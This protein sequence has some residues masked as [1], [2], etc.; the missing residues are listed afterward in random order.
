MPTIIGCSPEMSAPFRTSND[1]IF[2]YHQRLSPY[3]WLRHGFSL[4]KDRNGVEMSYA[5]NEYQATETVLKNRQRLVRSVSGTELRLAT[6]RQM[7]SDR[8]FRASQALLDDPPQGDGWVSAEPQLL[9]AVQTAD[10]LPL[11]LVD[12]QQRVVAAVH[13]GWRGAL[14]RIAQKAVCRMQTD[15]RS[16]PADCLAISGPAIRRCCYEVGDELVDAF[17]R[18]FKNADAFIFEAPSGRAARSHSRCVDLAGVCRTQL[19]DAGLNPE[20]ILTDGPC[21]ACNR[22]RFF[23]HR[24]GAGEAGRMMSAIGIVDRDQ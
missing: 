13:A 4:R 11:L 21:T 1:G 16:Q 7:H 8:V 5:L 3:K 10:C 17:S 14:M 18:E 19:L 6:L 15:F 23:S 20:N 9:V 12:P 2:L 22:D 24:A